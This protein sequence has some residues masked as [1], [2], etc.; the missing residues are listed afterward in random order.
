M[1]EC[2]PISTGDGYHGHT[3][4][5]ADVHRSG[6]SGS[7]AH[8][9]PDDNGPNQSDRAGNVGR[10]D[11]DNRAWDVHVCPRPA[12]EQRKLLARVGR[13]LPLWPSHQVASA[14]HPGPDL[15]TPEPNKNLSLI[16]KHIE[17]YP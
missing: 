11:Y 2:G 10:R 9:G 5:Y 16:A 17:A 13:L 8:S 1:A 15:T 7:D 4:G 12:S 3:V 6:C 14:P